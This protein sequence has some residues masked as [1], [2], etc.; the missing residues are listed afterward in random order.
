MKFPLRRYDFQTERKRMVTP[1]PLSLINDI[2]AILKVEVNEAGV[3]VTYTATSIE[4]KEFDTFKIPE[5]YTIV[6]DSI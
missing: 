4:L 2:G 3:I 1:F 6:N 5:G